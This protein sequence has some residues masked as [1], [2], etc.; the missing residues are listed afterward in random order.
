MTRLLFAIFSICV[1]LSTPPASADHCDNCKEEPAQYVSPF[2]SGG[3]GFYLEITKKMH[4]GV[5]RRFEWTTFY[6]AHRNMEFLT[7][8]RDHKPHVKSRA[9]EEFKEITTE[10]NG[11][12]MNCRAWEHH[13]E[14]QNAT[15]YSKEC[16]LNLGKGNY[17]LA[18]DQFLHFYYY[19]HDET[20]K[21]L[22]EDVIQS[23][24]RI[25]NF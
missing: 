13:I 5:R 2:L 1:L 22:A 18:G 4:V 3:V 12:E 25:Q 16:D 23:T 7:I 20:S 9:P 6:V 15:Y 21:N 24:R 11:M 10:V 14:L 19:N 8:I 17:K